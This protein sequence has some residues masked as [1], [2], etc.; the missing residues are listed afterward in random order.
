M[1]PGWVR[2]EDTGQEEEGEEDTRGVWKMGEET[3]WIS[4]KMDSGGARRYQAWSGMWGRKQERSGRNERKMECEKP[5]RWTLEE[6]GRWTQVEQG[7]R[8]WKGSRRTH[9]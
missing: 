1:K 4:D 2:G 8:M 3:G 5:G 7:T 6:H 9:G